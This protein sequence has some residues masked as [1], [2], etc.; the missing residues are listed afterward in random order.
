MPAK[1]NSFFTESPKTSFPISLLTFNYANAE[2]PL[3]IFLVKHYIPE[4][5]SSHASKIRWL[6]NNN[7]CV[8]F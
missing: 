8:F 5:Y 1:S 6:N 4:F 3:V 2:T 7:E